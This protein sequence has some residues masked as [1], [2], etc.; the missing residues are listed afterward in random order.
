MRRIKYLLAD[1]VLVLS[2]FNFSLAAA[3]RYDFDGDGKTDPMVLGNH[4]GQEY[5][6]ML[7]SSSGYHVVPWGYNDI[8]FTFQDFSVAADYDGD[9]KT[10]VAVFREPVTP[11]PI[12]PNGEQAHFFILYSS[13]GTSAVI[14]WGRSRNNT[15]SDGPVKG[16][17]DG[18]GKMDVAVARQFLGSKQYLYV[19]QSRDGFRLEQFGNTG[20]LGAFGDY[21]GDGTTDLGV[22]RPLCASAGCQ[23]QFFIKRSSNG[24]W[25]VQTFGFTQSD[26][27]LAGDYDGDGKTDIAVWSGKFQFGSGYW[28]WIRSSD[29]AFESVKWG[30]NEAADIAAPGDYDGDGKIDLTIYRPNPLG[31]CNVPSYFWIRGSSMGVNVIQFGTCHGYP[32]YDN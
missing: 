28:S 14:P 9:G 10:D 31:D 22:A 18:D 3:V 23:Y 11:Q 5:W 19:L 6:H 21:D 27:P 16:D 20:D 32:F 26:Y 30:S 25:L 2:C 24:T 4:F 15:F 29:G 12:P 8:N 7:D 17:F 1:T 13:T